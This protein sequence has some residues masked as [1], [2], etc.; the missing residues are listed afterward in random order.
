MRT[1]SDDI[2]SSFDP[3]RLSDEA[4]QAQHVMLR[5]RCE[6]RLRLSSAEIEK[7]VKDFL[8]S[9]GSATM[10]PT[11]YAMPSQQY[12]LRPRS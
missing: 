12:R 9:H 4:L 11:A 3:T 6:A 1:T 8:T 5:D 2:S 7:M 10:C